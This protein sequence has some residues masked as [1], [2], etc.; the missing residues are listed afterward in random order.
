M[1]TDE[2]YDSVFYFPLY[3]EPYSPLYDLQ[4]LNI[5]ILD[6]DIVEFDQVFGV[7]IYS[8]DPVHTAPNDT[9]I[10]VILPDGDSKSTEQYLLYLIVNDL[11]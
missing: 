2:D 5:T 6:D 1:N 8:N 4:C 9:A 7:A 10:V 11:N 3:F